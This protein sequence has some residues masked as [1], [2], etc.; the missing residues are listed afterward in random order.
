MKSY[1]QLEQ[2]V[3][4]Y[5]NVIHTTSTSLWIIAYRQNADPGIMLAAVNLDKSLKEIPNESN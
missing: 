2:E 3:E 4:H 1:K 5:R